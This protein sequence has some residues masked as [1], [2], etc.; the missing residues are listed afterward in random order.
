MTT[1]HST[2]DTYHRAVHPRNVNGGR[3][4][5]EGRAMT[6]RRRWAY[7]NLPGAVTCVDT[8]AGTP[9]GPWPESNREYD[10]YR[11]TR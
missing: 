2:F 5:A 7:A 1:E 4:I 6:A 10:R 8:T 11:A 9:H 3:T